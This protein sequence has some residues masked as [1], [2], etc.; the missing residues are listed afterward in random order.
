MGEDPANLE[1]VRLYLRSL[2]PTALLSVLQ[3]FE[4]AMLRGDTVPEAVLAELRREIQKSGLQPQRVGSPSR[5]FFQPIEPFIVD[6]APP[7]RHHGYIARASLNPIWMWICRDLMPVDSKAYTDRAR[8][9]LLA[10]D[11]D[12]CRKLAEA[13]Q[14]HFVKLAAGALAGPANRDRARERLAIYMGPPRAV[15]DLCETFC[16]LKARHVLANVASRL[17]ERI[18]DLKDTEL[19][20]VMSLLN[21]L[22]GAPGNALLYA[23]IITM[24]RLGVRWQLVRLAVRA[25]QSKAAG[26]V[27]R[28]PYSEAIALVLVDI[29][30]KAAALRTRLRNR[31]T[32]EARDLLEAAHAA[33]V[34]VAREL[35]LTEDSSLRRRCAAIRADVSALLTAEVAAFDAGIQ[36]LLDR[37]P[38]QELTGDRVVDPADLAEAEH[39]LALVSSIAGMAEAFDIRD[40]VGVALSQARMRIENAAV[41]LLVAA[42]Q[43]GGAVRRF[44]LERF[45]AAVRICAKLFGRDFT[46]ALAGKAGTAIR[47]GRSPPP[48]ETEAGPEPM[49]DAP[50]RP[51]DPSAA[52][53]K[54]GRHDPRSAVFPGA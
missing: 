45:E 36:R 24:R 34:A 52:A 41:A 28:T 27:V 33:I 54:D 15:D 53:G 40:A 48:V 35:D 22:A 4:R 51:P 39:E 12:T 29:E 6:G 46:S 10:A 42:R 13:F 23:L 38:P 9:A 50:C 37:P 31:E 17:P 16:V 43:A 8:R 20:Q 49:S 21:P 3:E 25:A 26:R 47:A 2:P 1:R 18:D 32:K 5:L 30:G 14:D 11:Q 7:R 19:D 44:Y